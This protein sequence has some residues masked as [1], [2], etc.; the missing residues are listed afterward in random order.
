MGRVE[1][2]TRREGGDWERGARSYKL[3]RMALGTRMVG[4]VPHPPFLLIRPIF[5]CLLEYGA[6]ASKNIRAPEKQNA[7]RRCRLPKAITV[8]LAVLVAVIPSCNI[9]AKLILVTGLLDK[10][11]KLD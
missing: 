3:S 11:D 1:I 8:F 6:F 10:P 2:A 7:C 5:F 9:N 4:G